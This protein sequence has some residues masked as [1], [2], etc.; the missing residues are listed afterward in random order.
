MSPQA[1]RDGLEA[2]KGILLAGPPGTGKTRLPEAIAREWG[3]SWANLTSLTDINL[4]GSYLG[5]SR[6]FSTSAT[7][8]RYVR[9]ACVTQ[10]S[11]GEPSVLLTFARR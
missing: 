3:V 9:G 4:T 7:V 11:T 10:S 8:K 2:P 6:A 1:R 5:V